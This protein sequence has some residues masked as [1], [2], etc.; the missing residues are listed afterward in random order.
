MAPPPLLSNRAL[1]R[2]TL[3]R[4]GLIK[5][6]PRGSIADAVRRIG[7]LQ[8]QHPEW[9]PVALWSRA[10]ERAIPGLANAL[11]D[12]SVVRAALMR[13]TVHVVAA[14]DFWP[15][16]TLAQPLR[17]QQFRAF[18]KRQL[19]H[20]KTVYGD[21]RFD[22]DDR[23]GMYLWQSP[24]PLPLVS[25]YLPTQHAA[26]LQGRLHASP[27]SWVLHKIREVAG[28]YAWACGLGPGLPS[29]AT[30]ASRAARRDTT[31]WRAR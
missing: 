17:R 25:Q 3:A 12:R 14:T 24:P 9:P 21:A 19:T 16:S 18:F 26:L 2:A 8:A 30:G 5:P 7:S 1:G 15:M 20:V 10:G 13:I 11:A 31:S 28:D 6:L 22:V 29:G 23:K 4:Q 27:R